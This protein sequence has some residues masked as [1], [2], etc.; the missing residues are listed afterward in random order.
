MASFKKLGSRR[1]LSTLRFKKPR[2]GRSKKATARRARGSR[3][4]LS[5]AGVM[6]G[7]ASQ[8]GAGRPRG[9]YKYGMPIQEWKKLQAKRKA[10]LKVYQQ[11]QLQRLRKR[12]FTKEEFVEAQIDRT[13]DDGLPEP[14]E[15]VPDEELRFQEWLAKNTVSPNTQ[16]IID[17]QRRIQLK[18]KRDDINQ[19]RIQQE[20]RL[21]ESKGNL[22]KA[23]QNLHKVEMDF[24]G[25]DP[26]TN[27]LMAP[28]T[29]KEVPGNKVLRDT[30]KPSILQTREAGN[31]LF[32]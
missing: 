30:G 27:I 25:V 16:R 2:V 15:S 13:V 10:L 11:Q 20:R 9:T 4:I 3:N 1:K 26:T 7:K 22:L 14:E 18:G 31:S 19:Q 6:G 29:F 17:R 23:H 28:N 24:T 21:V 5:A 12:G 8:S 32:F